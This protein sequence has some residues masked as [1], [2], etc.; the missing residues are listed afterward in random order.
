MSVCVGVTVT[1]TYLS[2][3]V[4]ALSMRNHWSSY[5]HVFSFKVERISLMISRVYTQ[6]VD[7]HEKKWYN[8]YIRKREKQ[9]VKTKKKQKKAKKFLTG[10]LNYGIITE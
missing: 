8:I 2:P 4:G 5:G 10:S 6:K 7:C 9:S 1:Y 3:G